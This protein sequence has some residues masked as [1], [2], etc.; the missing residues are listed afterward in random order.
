MAS[1]I[2]KLAL[3]TATVVA[4]AI[5]STACGGG[6]GDSA[7]PVNNPP[8]ITGITLDSIVQL[9]ALSA[10]Q[11]CVSDDFSNGVDVSFN[12]ALN[13]PVEKTIALDTLGNGCETFAYVPKKAGTAYI[14][15]VVADKGDTDVGTNTDPK[16]TFQNLS[17]TVK[18]YHNPDPNTLGIGNASG[19]KGENVYLDIGANAQ[20]LRRLGSDI[21]FN[22]DQLEFVG[23]TPNTSA[24]PYNV[25]SQ[26]LDPDL[27]PI[28][29]KL[30]LN[31][32]S[33]GVDVSN[34]PIGTLEFKVLT[35]NPQNPVT[36][37]NPTYRLLDTN[38]TL[39]VDNTGTVYNFEG[40]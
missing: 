36:L 4:A 25:V 17:Q 6:G 11:V 30:Q 5:L 13:T 33:A 32:S 37:V 26:Y 7:P 12:Y 2:S 9:G 8:V 24:M 27:N 15:L 20:G 1:Y 3:T 14:G 39:T 34:E 16:E 10:A 35:T 18:S 28:P 31:I 23:Y 38:T 29:G 21:I 19:N 22:P 40:L